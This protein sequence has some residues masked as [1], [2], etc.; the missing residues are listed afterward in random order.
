MIQ[1]ILHWLPSIAYLGIIFYLSSQ[2]KPLDM[3][4]GFKGIDKF[5][6]IGE[7]AMTG[8]LLF[9][10]LKKSGVKRAFI[11][12]FILSTA[13]G[14]SDEIHQSLV[15]NRSS[16]LFDIIAD[17][18]GSFIGAYSGMVL[19]KDKTGEEVVR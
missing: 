14:I 4:I 13:Y 12:A 17:M 6:H 15:P 1:K 3:D 11:V 19:I 2:S 18:L 16:D 5:L 9:F 10:S 7:Y 8:F